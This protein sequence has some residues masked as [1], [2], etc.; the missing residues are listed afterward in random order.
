MFIQ[1]LK[2]LKSSVCCFLVLLFVWV[3]L[4]FGFLLVVECFLTELNG[5]TTKPKPAQ[6]QCMMEPFAW[7]YV[8]LSRMVVFPS[9]LLLS[10]PFL[11]GGRFFSLFFHVHC[12]SVLQVY[13]E[14]PFMTQGLILLPAK[15]I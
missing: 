10:E 2:N 8:F 1:D 6:H 14:T 12:G 11:T 9:M 4:V 15:Q 13:Q 3:F 5:E 7:S